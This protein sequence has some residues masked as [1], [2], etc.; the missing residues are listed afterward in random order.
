MLLL[1]FVAFQSF[2]AP[3]GLYSNPMLHRFKRGDIFSR[4][5]SEVG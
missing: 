4:L 1:L 5:Q 3:G 2:A